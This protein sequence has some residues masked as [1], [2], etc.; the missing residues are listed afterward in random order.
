MLNFWANDVHGYQ[1]RIYTSQIEFRCHI[2][3]KLFILCYLEVDCKPGAGPFCPLMGIIRPATGQIDSPSKSYNLG[4]L[5]QIYADS[6]LARI[7]CQLLGR[8][9][10]SKTFLRRRMYFGVTSTNSSSAMNS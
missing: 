7:S 8:F 6:V 10:A 4:F 1:P 5:G 9:L 3:Y 2:S